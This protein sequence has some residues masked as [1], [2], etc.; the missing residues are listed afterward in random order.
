MSQTFNVGNFFMF[1]AAK[2]CLEYKKASDTLLVIINTYLLSNPP[3]HS[4]SDRNK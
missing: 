2:G 4:D 3:P 1:E